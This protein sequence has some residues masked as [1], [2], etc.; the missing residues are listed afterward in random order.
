MRAR[1]GQKR[2]AEHF[3]SQMEGRRALDAS[4]EESVGRKKRF[5][6]NS[7]TMK[8]L[9]PL[10]VTRSAEA[11]CGARRRASAGDSAAAALRS[12]DRN[13]RG[14]SARGAGNSSVD[15]EKSSRWSTE[16]SS[17]RLCGRKDQTLA[18]TPLDRL[19]VR[20]PAVTSRAEK[21]KRSET[22][23]TKSDK[24]SAEKTTTGAPTK[25]RES[26]EKSQP[27]D[28]EGK[29][30]KSQAAENCECPPGWV[31]LPCCT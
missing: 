30:Q 25:L 12:P 17:A 22:D 29:D 21:F 8:K 18:E 16:N 31:A 20:R 24:Y 28:R 11:L 2:N 4:K 23:M 3:Q 7:R 1:D 14:R 26:A 15:V 10:L 6:C 19:V 27:A 13:D 5:F 9:D